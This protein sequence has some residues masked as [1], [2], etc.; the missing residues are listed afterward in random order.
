MR[1]LK[2]LTIM[3]VW[4]VAM[5]HGAARPDTYGLDG[6]E[7]PEAEEDEGDGTPFARG[8]DQAKMHA[9]PGW[10]PAGTAFELLLRELS[11][12]AFRELAAL[13]WYGRGDYETF[14]DALEQFSPEI[15]P[16]YLASKG[17]L[18]KYLLVGLHRLQRDDGRSR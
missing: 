3:Q 9:T 15:R 5:A 11:P 8:S 1:Q 2:H 17:P 7:P 12:E 18:K 10:N 14:Q 6:D 16:G 13:M 4:T